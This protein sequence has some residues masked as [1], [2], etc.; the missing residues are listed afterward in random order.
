ML[1]SCFSVAALFR[2]FISPVGSCMKKTPSRLS[3]KPKKIKVISRL[4]HGFEASLLMPA[5][6]KMTASDMPS[7]TK[8]KMMPRP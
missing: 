4:T 1:P 5:A 8:V 6:P 7:A 2:R 3:A